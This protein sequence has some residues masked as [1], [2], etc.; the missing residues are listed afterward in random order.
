MENYVPVGIRTIDLCLRGPITCMWD[1][2]AACIAIK[3]TNESEYSM[4][5]N[6]YVR[7]TGEILLITFRTLQYVAERENMI[8][9]GLKGLQSR[10][11]KEA[12]ITRVD[13]N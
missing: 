11:L 2:Q 7:C 9:Q 4:K 5:P 1:T 10:P 3:V 13:S 12:V 6:V 8:K